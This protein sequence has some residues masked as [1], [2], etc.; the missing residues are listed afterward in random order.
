MFL[1]IQSGSVDAESGAVYFTFQYVSINTTVCRCIENLHR[2]F[3]FQ[4]VSINTIYAAIAG[5]IADCFTFQ[6]VSINTKFTDRTSL[7]QCRL[8]IPICFY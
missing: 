7:E 2:S 6:Y 1:L 8:Y 3:T 4:Y 5:V